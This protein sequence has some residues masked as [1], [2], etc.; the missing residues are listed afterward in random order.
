LTAKRKRKQREGA[1]LVEWLIVSSSFCLL[2]GCMF[3]V[4]AYCS[5]QLRSLD[6]ARADAW[7]DAMNGCVE[8][9]PKL[10]EIGNAVKDGDVPPPFAEQMLPSGRSAEKTFTLNH[11][12]LPRGLT[13]LS[14]RREVKFICNPIPGRAVPTSDIVGWLKDWL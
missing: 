10:G 2:L 8:G 11:Q 13:P 1:V 12:G 6:E 9:S 7:A 4:R 5:M 14:G 3:C